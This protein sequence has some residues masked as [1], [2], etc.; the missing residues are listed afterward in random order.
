[1]RATGNSRL[2]EAAMKLTK[3]QIDRFNRDG[4][5]VLPSLLSAAEVELLRAELARV[6][7]IVDVRNMREGNGETPRIVYGLPDVDGPT[8]SQAYWNLARDHRVLQPVMDILEE[9]V[10]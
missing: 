8:F 5:L 6:S 10:S 9:D 1:M 3:E 4:F 7:K 2:G